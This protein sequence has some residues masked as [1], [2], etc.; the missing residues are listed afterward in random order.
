MK[1]EQS[2]NIIIVEDIQIVNKGLNHMLSRSNRFNQVI[3]YESAEDMIEQMPL[4]SFFPDVVIL[5]LGLPGLSGLDCLLWLKERSERVRVLIFTVFG[6]NEKVFEAIQLGADGY[7]LK[8]ESIENILEAIEDAIQ[9][10]A[11]MSREIARKVLDSFKKIKSPG[12]N[13]LGHFNLNSK[14]ISVLELLSKGL[15]Y[16]EIAVQ[17]NTTSQTVKQ[18]AHAIYRKM[19][20]RNKTEALLQY[21][22]YR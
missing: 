5:D 12:S 14:E 6:S 22:Q 2:I 9:G 1:N 17:M 3:G 7:L 11:P 21:L 8:S 19:H 15:M 20:V 10:G 18:Y 13:R 16:K 4:L